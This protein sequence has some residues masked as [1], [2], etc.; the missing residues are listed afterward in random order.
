M[1]TNIFSRPNSADEAVILMVLLWTTMIPLVAE[2]CFECKHKQVRRKINN[3][4]RTEETQ[5]TRETVSELDVLLQK[6]DEVAKPSFCE[7]EMFYRHFSLTMPTE[8]FD[9][10]RQK[11]DLVAKILV[12]YYPEED[13]GI[14]KTFVTELFQSDD[15]IFATR[16]VWIGNGTIWKP[17]YYVQIRRIY[18]TSEVTPKVEERHDY[19]MME[20]SPWLDEIITTVQGGIKSEHQMNGDNDYV[21]GNWTK[22]Y[23]T[24]EGRRWLL[25]YTILLYSRPKKTIKSLIGVL[26]V[27]VDV[28]KMDVNQCDDPWPLN[29]FSVTY[30]QMK[31]FLGTH[32]CHNKSS[33][34]HGIV[35]YF[36]KAFKGQEILE[37]ALKHLF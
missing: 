14:L 3:Y 28:T 20:D 13:E 22:P 12:G 25:S 34:F 18:N 31:S 23:F 36:D 19:S 29:N 27:D 26:G 2:G 30:W 8:L 24:C 16:I 5:S 11:V 1:K 21:L 9:I 10:V 35:R 4:P 32:K 7:R 15:V 33:E 37:Q 6:I 17:F